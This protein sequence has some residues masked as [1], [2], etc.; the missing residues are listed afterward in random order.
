[1]VRTLGFHCRGMGL[2]PDGV[3]TS[4]QSKIKHALYKTELCDWD[5]VKQLNWLELVGK[6]ERVEEG[7]GQE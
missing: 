3:K 6:T 4:N 5:K 2:I 1:M 7:R